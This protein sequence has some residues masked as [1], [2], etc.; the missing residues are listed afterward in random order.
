MLPGT[1]HVPNGDDFRRRVGRQTYW[2]LP[3]DGNSLNKT[4]GGIFFFFRIY[5]VYLREKEEE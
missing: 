1:T 5:F 2:Y 4:P 3:K